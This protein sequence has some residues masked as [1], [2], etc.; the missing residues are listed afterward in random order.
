VLALTCWQFEAFS[1]FRNKLI[2]WPDY[3]RTATDPIDLDQLEP[4]DHL[5]PW[6]DRGRAARYCHFTP[7]DEMRR[8]L[9]DLSFDL[10]S[11][12]S[13]DGREENL[14]QYFICRFRSAQEVPKKG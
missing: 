6:G 11:N 1:R 3:N 10:V 12:Y 9:S 4:G 14:N 7:E 8:L 13:A 2:P 5:L